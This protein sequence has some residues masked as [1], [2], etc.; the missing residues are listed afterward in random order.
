[1]KTINITY[2]DFEELLFNK[3]KSLSAKELGSRSQNEVKL[4]LKE[5]P[6]ID[7]VNLLFISQIL[8]VEM[9]TDISFPHLRTNYGLPSGLMSCNNQLKTVQYAA[10]MNPYD[11]LIPLYTS[12]RRALLNVSVWTIKNNGL[13]E[14]DFFFN[15][16]LPGLSEA[17]TAL[18]LCI[19]DEITLHNC[20]PE[21]KPS[22]ESIE[23]TRFYYQQIWLGKH[24][25][26]MLLH[27]SKMSD[28]QRIWFMNPFEARQN[29]SIEPFGD[30]T[31]LILA[32]QIVL[33]LSNHD[34]MSY[35]YLVAIMSKS[36][37]LNTE[38]TSNVRMF[39]LFLMGLLQK[40]VDNYFPVA[41]AA[42]LFRHLELNAYKIAKGRVFSV[43]SIDGFKKVRKSQ[44]NPIENCVAYYR[45][46]NPNIRN[47]EVAIF[48]KTKPFVFPDMLPVV[49][50]DQ[51]KEFLLNINKLVIVDE[52]FEQMLFMTSDEKTFDSLLS[53][54][55]NAI[56]V[57][58]SCVKAQMNE[59]N[60]RDLFLLNPISSFDSLLKFGG[61]DLNK[62]HPKKN[63]INQ[64]SK[65]IVLIT[66][67]FSISS[68]VMDLFLG[69]NLPLSL[70]VFN[71]ESANYHKSKAKNLRNRADFQ[72]EL[73]ATFSGIPVR[74]VSKKADDPNWEMV[75]IGIN[76]LNK[77]SLGCCMIVD[78]RNKDRED[79]DY[80][81]ILRAF[82]DV[83]VYD[84]NQRYLF[85][86]L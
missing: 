75:H 46:K 1:M 10:L 12:I 3:I 69:L 14:L 61:F 22:V 35:E 76:M 11:G 36:F 33:E 40:S 53:V 50:P 48:G 6:E 83:V 57:K 41:G 68:I 25:S 51:S 64:D 43:I 16:L 7:Q 74:I 34:K 30:T 52:I 32:Y 86:N 55:K 70:F 44:N 15:S 8:S 59:W 63:L 78:V 60:M 28:E 13:D 54:S 73:E 47:K 9:A 17:T 58:P 65:N 84:E 72:A 80:E 26:Q 67:D 62:I 20:I 24:I 29:R 81:I 82:S 71:F 49:F 38:R 77:T 23:D 79:S 42:D 45:I 39:A 37:D 18:L 31:D 4:K 2:N 66:A 27:G 5:I 19:I 56:L 85:M 21:S